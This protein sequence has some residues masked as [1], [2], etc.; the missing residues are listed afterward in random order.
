MT[1]YVKKLTGRSVR[2]AAKQG[3]RRSSGANTTRGRPL[4][5]RTAGPAG[6]PYASESVTSSALVAP[7][8]PLLSGG[9]DCW[10]RGQFNQPTPLRA[11]KR[12]RSAIRFAGTLP[13]VRQA[14]ALLSR[15][16]LVQTPSSRT[17][18]LP[19]ERG[20][21]TNRGTQPENT[22][23]VE[24]CRRRRAAQADLPSETGYGGALIDHWAPDPW[25]NP[26]PNVP[27]TGRSGMRR[28]FCRAPQFS[29]WNAG[30]WSRVVTRRFRRRAL[31]SSGSQVRVLPGHPIVVQTNQVPE[32][33]TNSNTST[34]SILGGTP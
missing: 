26:G 1:T 2:P 27:D 4:L 18:Q 7:R 23:L 17:L 8:L 22:L 28:E 11:K 29:V 3:R 25:P 9:R 16:A 14:R 31:L 32:L 6:I 13:E 24:V 10:P 20:A 5:K 34:Y 21:I 15:A 19:Q 30:L 33:S 12:V